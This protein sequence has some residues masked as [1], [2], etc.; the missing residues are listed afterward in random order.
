MYTPSFGLIELAGTTLV[1]FGGMG[2]S[3]SILSAAT[4]HV[5]YGVTAT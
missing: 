2:A 4:K 3:P 5:V 1:A